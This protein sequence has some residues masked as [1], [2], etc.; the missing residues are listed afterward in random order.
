[1][2]NSP[3]LS[4]LLDFLHVI[5]YY[6]KHGRRLD[7]DLTHLGTDYAL[8]IVA[9]SSDSPLPACRYSVG[10]NAYVNGGGGIRAPGITTDHCTTNKRDIGHHRSIMEP[11]AES[12]RCHWVLSIAEGVPCTVTI[13]QSSIAVVF[14]LP[15]VYDRSSRIACTAE[16][17]HPYA[18]ACLLR[19]Q[20]VRHVVNH[21]QILK[22][23]IILCHTSH[24]NNNNQ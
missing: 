4:Q 15:T 3:L 24:N 6:Q 8:P 23:S 22:T 14:I 7:D 12:E 5:S 18:C 2:G 17:L 19:R 11:E 10:C 16:L 21:N 20:N 9:S 1:M 13:T